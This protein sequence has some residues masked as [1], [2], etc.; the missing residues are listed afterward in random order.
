MRIGETLYRELLRSAGFLGEAGRIYRNGF[1]LI[2]EDGSI[3]HFRRGKWLH[4]PLGAVLDRPIGKWVEDVSLREGD[5]FYRKGQ[6]LLRKPINGCSILLKPTYVVNLK[7]RLS[8]S[9]PGCETVLSWIQ[10]LTEEIFKWGKFEGMGGTL[11][12]LKRALSDIFSD[13]S[14][15]LNLWSRHALPRVKKLV[16]SVFDEDCSVFEDAWGELL[17]LGPGLTPASDD[18][19]VGFLAAHKLFSSPFSKGIE[20]YALKEKL[21]EHVRAKTVPIASQFLNCALEGT[22]SEI[23]YLAFGDL[24]LAG[25]RK[26]EGDCWDPESG[27]GKQIKKFLKWGHSSGTDVLTGAVFGL[28]T[29]T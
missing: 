19:M 5:V 24:I 25:R 20:D 9:P 8:L 26:G 2:K 11:I 4:S 16:Q 28:W 23:L 6:F 22:F 3:I 10:L 7:R 12:L 29:M 21:R 13:H 27:R 17:G 18:F 15:P 14:I 1:D